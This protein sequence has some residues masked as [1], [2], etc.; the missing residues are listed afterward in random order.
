MRAE[1]EGSVSRPRGPASKR[2]PILLPDPL[3]LSSRE[4]MCEVWK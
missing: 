4:R 2:P 3:F 1:A